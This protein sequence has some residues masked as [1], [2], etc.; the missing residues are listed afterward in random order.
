MA[1]VELNQQPTVLFIFYFH[2]IQI[3]PI[4]IL[5]HFECPEHGA[6][7]GYLNFALIFSHQYRATQ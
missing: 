5:L 1:S 6:N 4:L 3:Y 2:A 7:R